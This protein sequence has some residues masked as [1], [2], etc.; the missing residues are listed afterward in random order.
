M[1]PPSPF[2]LQEILLCISIL[3][4]FAKYV[5]FLIN[6][7]VEGRWAS[8]VSPVSHGVMCFASLALA[9]LTNLH[10]PTG[11]PRLFGD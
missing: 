2:T 9:W 6:A 10:T 1:H 3:C 11:T 7:Q 8:R 4:T 5:L